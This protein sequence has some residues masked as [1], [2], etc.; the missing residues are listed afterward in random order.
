[1]ARMQVLATISLL[2]SSTS[3]GFL[4]SAAMTSAAHAQATPPI[5]VIAS[6][7]A[8]GKCLDAAP[9]GVVLWDC[10]SGPNQAF[11]FRSGD[12]GQISLGGNQC[13]TGG[14]EGAALTM[15]ACSYP[16]QNQMWAF[17][18]DGTLRNESG[19]CADIERGASNSGAR[20]IMWSC[21]AS[22]NQLFY[23]A[24]SKRAAT[25]DL[26]TLSGI[27]SSRRGV[28]AVAGSLGFSGANLV[29]AGGGNLVAAGGGNLVAAGGGNL[30]AAGGG[31]IV[32][33]GAGKLIQDGGAY[34]V[35]AG[36]GNVVPTGGGS[37]LPRNFNFFNPTGAGQLVGNDGA[38]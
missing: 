4:A 16:N 30:V 18:P 1:M 25:V 29:A 7:F 22:R 28:Q 21:A 27:A 15:R 17:A 19:R 32:V 20:I 2:A 6:Y 8:R 31:N 35:A 34:L 38:S 9:Q 12:Y 26:A 11:R 5:P 36:G 14:G 13:L 24:V 33:G 3:L 10:H 37:L 23:P